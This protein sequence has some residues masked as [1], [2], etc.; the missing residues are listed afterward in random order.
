MLYLT[1]RSKA[2]SFTAYKVLRSER[3][4]DGGQFLPMQLPV[5]TDHQLA[6]LERMSFGETAA[7]MLN[8]FFGTELT[9]WDVDFAVGRQVMT[10]ADAGHGVMVAES[11]HNPADSHD[12][13]V[14]RL[15]ALAMGEKFAPIK[16][17][18]WFRAVID[19]ALVFAS[20]GKL[21]RSGVYLF[22]IAVE[23]A[24]LQMLF[25]LRY[26]QKMG[27]PLG[28]IILGSL[29]ADGLWEFFSYG[30]YPTG[31]KVRPT[32]LEALL[33]LEFGHDT[34]KEYLHIAEKRGIYKLPLPQLHQLRDGLFVTVVGD[35]RAS[36]IADGTRR[37][38][39]YPMEITTARAF[40]ALQDYRA[41][42]GDKQKT[43]LFSR[44]AGKYLI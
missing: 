8:L 12:Y 7:F 44:G 32:G 26:A 25:A 28:K 14:S 35:G 40:G 37:A 22:D 31:R 4:P 13:M 43:L 39:G 41:K 30:D 23:T 18:L 1:T 5:L 24:D 42:F 20:Y 9:G 21:C 27:L 11:W 2:D 17:S 34:V 3:A 19:I 38:G 16:P 29:E 33:W 36:D 6:A 10:L 15:L